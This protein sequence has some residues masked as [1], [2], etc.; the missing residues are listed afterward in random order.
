MARRANAT[1]TLSGS[2]VN[3]TDRTV[4]GLPH[5]TR[6]RPC[7]TIHMHLRQLHYA[8]AG[9]LCCLEQQQNTRFQHAACTLA[10]VAA[11]GMNNKTCTLR[12]L[13]MHSKC[14]ASLALY[15]AII[16]AMRTHTVTN[17]ACT[18]TGKLPRR[19]I[20]VSQIILAGLCCNT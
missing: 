9:L 11:Q 4:T 7:T 16:T 18:C 12:L 20:K 17:D 15:P 3:Q 13:A 2:A 10:A 14:V 19:P 5:V 1:Q 6:C 8:M